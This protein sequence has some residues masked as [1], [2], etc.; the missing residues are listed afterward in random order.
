MSG[1]SGAISHTTLHEATKGNR[2]PSW[3]TTTEFVRACGADPAAYRERWER[4]NQAVR[5]A[6]PPVD[7]P[8]DGVPHPLPAQLTVPPQPDRPNDEALSAQTT[9]PVPERRRRVRLTVPAALALT[10]IGVG[11]AVLIMIVIYRGFE[12]A[13]PAPSGSAAPSLSAI[14]CPIRQ[15]NPPPAPPARNGDASKFRGDITLTDCTHVGPGETVTKVW[16]L[17]NTGKVHWKGYSLRRLEPQHP[18]QCQTPAE[19]PVKETK[20]GKM[21]DIRVDII[22]P[23]KPGFCFVRFKM[24]N[25]SKEVVF[26]G[27]RPI[28]FQLIIDENS[29]SPPR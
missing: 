16:R 15:P 13:D 25:A 22:T 6:D 24:L 26:P 9:R 11:A 5:G 2:L 7:R 1:R 23:T 17:E 18:D 8:P 14:D 27:S 4:A 10:T 3:E 12:P 29:G 28:N 20:P 19:V 21:V